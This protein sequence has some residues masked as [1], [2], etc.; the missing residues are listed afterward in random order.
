[1]NWF[2]YMLATPPPLFIIIISLLPPLKRKISKQQNPIQHRY[3]PSLRT[4]T[5]KVEF[6]LLQFKRRC[7]SFGD[8]HQSEYVSDRDKRREFV[9]GFTRSLAV[10]SMN[11]ALLWTD[12]RYFFQVALELSD[13]L[14]LM[15]MGGD[16]AVDVWMV[17]QKR[18]FY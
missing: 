15:R 6:P 11:E 9:F 8:Y 18:R 1:M 2:V 13:Q 3:P 12:G 14:K 10:I 16:P 7:S 17:D 5:R 4:R